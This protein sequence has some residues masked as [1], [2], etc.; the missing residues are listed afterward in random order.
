MF[1]CV[2][3]IAIEIEH[4]IIFQDQQQTRPVVVVVNNQLNQG[5]ILLV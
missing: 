1:L 3:D 4:L 5:G 2:H